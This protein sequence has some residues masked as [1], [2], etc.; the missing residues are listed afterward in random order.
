M[1]PDDRDWV[2]QLR[3]RTPKYRTKLPELPPETIYLLAH[4]L[5]SAANKSPP[6]PAGVAPP[7]H[8][9][10]ERNRSL[11][12]AMFS[13]FV[14]RLRFVAEQSGGKLGLGAKGGNL[15]KAIC[16]LNPHLPKGLVPDRLRI[17]TLRNIRNDSL[18]DAPPSEYEFF[19]IP[20]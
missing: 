3:R 11:K 17:G 15:V 2:E 16:L 8:Q 4:L 18:F 14:R 13:D 6:R 9:K 12:D 20:E 1:E 19:F 10:S 5:S 7:S